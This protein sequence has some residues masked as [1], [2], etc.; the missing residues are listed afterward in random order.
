MCFLHLKVLPLGTVRY[1]ESSWST[2]PSLSCYEHR[3]S[4][5]FLQLVVS[6][7][8]PPVSASILLVFRFPYLFLCLLNAR[9][10]HG[11]NRLDCCPPSLESKYYRTCGTSIVLWFRNL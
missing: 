8:I 5:T 9:V 7:S 10:C 3:T 2:T 4:T 6:Y 1:T 11:P